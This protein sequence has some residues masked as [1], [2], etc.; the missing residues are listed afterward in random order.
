[1]KFDNAQFTQ[2]VSSTLSALEKLKA[3]MNL[4]NAGAAATKS[5]GAVSSML[6]R[7]GLSNPF[8]KIT[9]AFTGFASRFSIFGSKNHLAPAQAG[10]ADLQK[11]ANGFTMQGLEGSVTG[12]S[13]SFI[14]MST[15]AITALSNI[16]NKAVDAGLNIAKSLTVQPI[17]TGL[18]EYETNLNSI[19]TILANTK[20]SGATLKDVNAALDE[21]NTYSDK[22]IYNFSE[23]ARNIGT[24]TAAGVGLDESVASIKGIANL[25]ALSGSNSQQAATAMYQLSQEIAAGR[26]SLMGWN[27]V[28]NAGMGGSTFQRALAQTA[29]AMGEIP[30]SAVKLEGA[31]KNVKIEGQSFRDSIMAKP[32]EVSWLTKEVLT[33]TLAQF[34]GDMSKAQ[35]MA[36]GFTES[37]AESIQATARTAMSAAQDVKTLSGVFDVAKETAASGWARTWQL[38]FG[39]FKEAKT[40]FT[41]FSTAFSGMIASA[42]EKRNALLE[43]WDELGGRDAIIDA[44]KNAFKALL[45]VLAPVK[46]AFRDIFPATT[47]KELFNMTTAFR[48]FMKALIPGK[49]TAE[50]IRRTFAGVFAIFSIIGQVIG[51]VASQF[52]RLFGAIGK[53]SG[54]FLNFTGGIGDVLVAFDAMLKKSGVIK[55][56]F[57]GIGDILAVPLRLI[58]NFAAALG[59]MFSGFDGGKA[60]GVSESISNVTDKLDPLAS[61]GERIK[62]IFAGVGQFLSSLAEGI[63][64]AL[65]DIGGA[66][67]EN[68][69]GD[70]FGRVLETINTGLF[71][72]MVLLLKKFVTDGLNFGFKGEIGGGFMDQLSETLQSVT[73]ALTTMQAS[74]KAN[75][76]LKIAAAIGIM[77]ASLLLLSM[78][79]PESL[80]KALGA[81]V[82][83]F[84]AMALV[85]N[86]LAGALSII[87]AAK[88]PLIAASF[89]L[90]AGSILVLSVA[91]KIMSSIEFGDML[92]G[93][94]GMALMMVIL[95]KSVTALS[96]N[97]GPMLRASV[98]LI[99]IGVALNILAVALKLFASM[100]WGEMTQGLLGVAGALVVLAAGMRI[101]PKGIV[102]QAAGITILAVALNILALAVRQFGSMDLEQMAKGLYGIGGTLVVIAMAMRL[103]PVSLPVTAAGLL[104]VS[105][106]LVIMASA[107]K[108]M[109]TMSWEDVAKGL[110]TVAGMLV[111]LAAGLNAMTFALLGAAALVVAVAALWLLAPVLVT[112]GAMSWESIAKGLVAIAGTFIVLGLAGLALAP[113]VPVIL[114]LGVSLL[115]LGAGMFL[116]GAGAIMMASAVR[117]FVGA[118]TTGGKAVASFVKDIIKQIP[119]AMKAFAKG[120]VGMVTVIAKAGPQMVRAF[121]AI[122]SSF[123]KAIIKNV[124]LMGKA[125]LTM[126]NTALRVIV[127]AT[128]RIVSAG[129][130][131]IVRF[132]QAISK[133]IGKMTNLA[134]DIIVK[135]LNGISRNIGRIIQ[136]GVNLIIKFIN[137]VSSAIDRN[138][139]RMGEAGARLA[140]AIV[141]GMANGIWSGASSIANAALGVAKSALNTAKNFLGISSPSKEFAKVGMY[142]SIGMAEGISKYGKVVDKSAE[143][144]G[145]SAL[146]TM[147]ATL[148]DLHFASPGGLDLQPTITPVL[149]LSSVRRE[150]VKMGG[151]LATDKLRP[152]VSLD[153]AR[154]ISRDTEKATD[155]S[156]QVDGT[157]VVKEIKFE[158]NNYSPKAISPTETYRNTKNQLNLAKEALEKS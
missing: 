101:M 104:L 25:A 148:S 54:G 85:M 64:E 48:D 156:T 158:Q 77:A 49:E 73:S 107:L 35:I 13:K 132:L 86:T 129:L 115:A 68:F 135:F 78:I 125:F 128:P 92:R 152:G 57:T 2:G 28:V 72:A 5:L 94:T 37:Q 15:I 136:S 1:M 122:L 109:A 157:P 21:L 93:L 123:L 119:A 38:I 127:T 44:F 137:G 117:I 126:L 83:G 87:G 130:N 27:S 26:V 108:I 59:A 31:M 11:S 88:L 19:Q 10:I 84:G 105:G 134:A 45:G 9:T 81:M 75:I 151:L 106:A 112:L 139:G 118:I 89:V 56:F 144:V 154:G 55:G 33:G 133:N 79:K 30:A 29:V 4:G 17:T 155:I 153:S 65:S 62:T 143:N 18:K 43:G 149:D 90:L 67:A 7:F 74:L 71:A 51:A 61:L 47:A 120:I 32:G 140:M 147:Q 40:L 6:S 146:K 95:T 42:A 63:V 138:S 66:I 3:S 46:A 58:Q 16:V 114:A 141:R 24:F 20:A 69:T 8:S 100:S 50:D 145:N 41:N 36:Q 121:S 53:G 102:L 150:A 14:A 34:T 110:V 80:A 142:S 22:T 76:L 39:D 91:L 116:A 82:V 111:I 60:G 96:A 52:G 113:V 124:P 99:A 12:V 131:L 98:A 23:M 70:V 103:M 97:S